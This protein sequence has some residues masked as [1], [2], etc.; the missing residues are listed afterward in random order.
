MIPALVHYRLWSNSVLIINH[1]SKHIC[2]LLTDCQYF[3]SHNS[4]MSSWSVLTTILLY[5]K[6]IN[7]N[8]NWGD[9]NGQLRTV[10]CMYSYLILTI[11]SY[12]CG[13]R[14]SCNVRVQPAQTHFNK[15]VKVKKWLGKVS[16]P[17]ILP[18]YIEAY[19]SS[20]CLSN[21]HAAMQV[22]TQTEI[23]FIIRFTD[24]AMHA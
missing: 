20:E 5:W 23:H 11:Y 12:V 24:L 4:S 6:R 8:N 17:L 22:C 10:N 14:W 1:T 3:R 9:S 19:N 18:A 15:L 2:M 21:N 7:N 13:V 16:L